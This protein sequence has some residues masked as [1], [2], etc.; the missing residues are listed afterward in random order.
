MTNEVQIYSYKVCLRLKGREFTS[1][2]KATTFMDLCEQIQD[3]FPGAQI[4][5]AIGG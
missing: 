4:V 1:Y 2:F 5:G 3:R